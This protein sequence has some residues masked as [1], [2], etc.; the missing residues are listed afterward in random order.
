LPFPANDLKNNHR[1][2]AGSAKQVILRDPFV[3]AVI[4]SLGPFTNNS[5]VEAA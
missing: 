3:F 4:L 5:F 1:K 2:D